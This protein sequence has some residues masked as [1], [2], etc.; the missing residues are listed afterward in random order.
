MENG[1]VLVYRNG[2]LRETQPYVQTN[3]AYRM[4]FERTHSGFYELDDMFAWLDTIV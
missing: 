4:A 3:E 1:Y 2:G